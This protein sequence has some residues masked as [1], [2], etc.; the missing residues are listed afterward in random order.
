SRL[1]IE[2]L[3]V[4]PGQEEV[5]ALR[6]RQSGLV[7]AASPEYLRHLAV[8]P[9]DHY[10]P[11]QWSLPKIDAP[12][13]WMTTLGSPKVMVAVIDSGDDFSHPD[14]PVHLIAGPTFVSSPSPS[15][16]PEGVNGPDDDNGHGTHVG[17][18]VAAAFDNGIGVAGLAPGVSVLVIKA[19]DCTGLLADSDIAQAIQDAADSGAKVINL[20]FGGPAPDPILDQAVQYAWGKGA[21]LVAA[22]GNDGSNEAF[23]P[24]SIPDVMAISATDQ[25]D[26][27]AQFSN[28]GPEIAVAAPG[29][30]IWSTVPT[31]VS[32]TG[33][34][35][36]SGTSM[37]APHVSA[38]AGLVW[39]I[40]PGFT[41]AQ[42]VQAV[43]RGAV[44]IGTVCPDTAFGYGRVDAAGA[45]AA[46]RTLTAASN[47]IASGL[48]FRVFL[49]SVANSRCGSP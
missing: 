18:I 30:G 38:V 37:A 9:D 40:A 43:E 4:A 11:E 34:A 46:V 42:V 47:R 26:A 20:S 28:R 44:R 41:N 19:A 39:S 1:G 6:L 17:G 21:V 31:F 45:L 13:A 29:V 32:S 14:R 23:Y 5:T 25:N 10:Y 22:A 3:R 33:Y 27:I 7:E 49:P 2:K 24:A 48:T 8:V 16:P 35:Q 15:C 36:E 12:T